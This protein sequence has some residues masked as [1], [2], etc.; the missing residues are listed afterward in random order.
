MYLCSFLILFIT[1]PAA[2]E[3]SHVK[4]DSPGINQALRRELLKMEKEDQ[5]YRMEWQER[6][7]KLPA[8][9]RTHPD[10]KSAAL[11]KKQEEVDRKNIE[12]LEQIIKEHGWPGKSLVGE[13][14]SQAAFLI[15]QH[16]ELK[17]QEAY[18]PLLKDAA[19]KGEASRADVALLEDRVLVGEGKK[20]IYGSQ[21]H[22]GPDTGGKWVIYPIEDEDQVDARRAAVGLPPMAEY[23]KLFNLEYK[24]AKKN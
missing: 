9:A 6:M 16:A 4:A 10:E 23:L 20:Q 14:A 18:L 21:L 22:F 19:A 11:A 5:K 7:I 2:F 17:R 8:D 12:R 13:K 24:P 15:L 3:P 1:L